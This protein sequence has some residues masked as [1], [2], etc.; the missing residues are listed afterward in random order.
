MNSS[1][2]KRTAA[3]RGWRR[4]AVAFNAATFRPECGAAPVPAS[5]SSVSFGSSCHFE[6]ASA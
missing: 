1:R 6:K 4:K 2:S 5:R 3:P